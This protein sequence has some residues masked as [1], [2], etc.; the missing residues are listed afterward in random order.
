MDAE[1]PGETMKAYQ[2]GTD[3][4]PFD[5]RQRKSARRDTFEF[6]RGFS[7][8]MR[9]KRKVAKAAAAKA[10]EESKA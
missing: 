4:K 5:R 9:E 6:N 2:F 8:L 3:G 10:A 7:K 1:V